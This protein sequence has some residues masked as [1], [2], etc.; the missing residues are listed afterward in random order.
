[1]EPEGDQKDQITSLIGNFGK[2]QA[3]LIFPLAFH[4][5]FGSFQTL[6]TPFLSLEVDNNFFCKNL[7]PKDVFMNLTQWGQF[8][9]PIDTVN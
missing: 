3:I 1:M 8:S 6:V 5:V 2:W 9:N 7:A 4:Y